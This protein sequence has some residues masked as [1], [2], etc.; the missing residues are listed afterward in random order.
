MRHGKRVRADVAG[1]EDQYLAGRQAV[2]SGEQPASAAAL[3]LAS[4]GGHLPPPSVAPARTYSSSLKPTPTPALGSTV[5]PVSCATP[6]GVSATRNSPSFTSRA[7]PMRI[8]RRAP[9][10]D[11]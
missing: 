10:R 9:A 7:M 6:A 8:R 5:T 11:R 4:H 1:A 2:Q 3:L